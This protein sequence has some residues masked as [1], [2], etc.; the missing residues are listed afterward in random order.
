MDGRMNWLL[1][2]LALLFFPFHARAFSLFQQQRRPRNISQEK[3][4]SDRAALPCLYS[5]HNGV[6]V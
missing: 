3:T 5:A 1:D 6:G 2:E 4:N